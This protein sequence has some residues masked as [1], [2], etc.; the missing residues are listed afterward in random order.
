[1]AIE[2]APDSPAMDAFAKGFGSEA[3]KPL[4]KV[5][6]TQSDCFSLTMHGTANS[7]P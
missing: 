7:H 2:D 1:M 3:S 6:L 5:T 4:L